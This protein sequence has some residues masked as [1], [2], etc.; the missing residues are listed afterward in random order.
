[1]R[2]FLDVVKEAGDLHA[3]GHLDRASILYENL[4]GAQPDDPIVLYLLGTLFSQQNRF[5][6]AITLLRA[7]TKTGGDE[8]P[9][10]WHNL[11]TAYRNEG[12]TEDA[13]EAYQKAL[14][15]E[16]D[17]ADTLAMMSGSY[18]NTGEPEKALDYADQSLAI[19]DSPQARNH[20]ALANLELGNWR[21]A[22]PDYEARFELDTHSVSNRPYTCPRWHGEKVKKLAIHGEQGV[23]DEIMFLSCYQ[24]ASQFAEEIVIEVEHRLRSLIEKSLEVP[25]YGSH[26]E[27]ITAHPDVDAY[28]PMGSLPGLFRN[29]DKDFPRN[30]YLKADGSKYKALLGD[31]PIVGIAWH[32]GTKGTHQQLRNAPLSLWKTLITDNPDKTFVSLQYGEDA[33]AQ[34]QELGI[35]HWQEVI[36][37]FEQQ[38][39]LIEA[40][41]LVVSVC[42][43]ATH[44]AGA[45]GAKCFCLTPD[46]AAWRYGLEG[47]VLWYGEHLEL[48]RQEGK[49]WEHVFETVGKRLKNADY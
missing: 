47:P 38:A 4:L 31:D 41:D 37:N 8:L 39:D 42:Q 21:E 24:D 36:D 9:E 16:S 34:A 29:D 27:L 26:Q 3:Q 15:L 48:I 35:I 14:A 6:S 2:E 23:G 10:V 43:T 46:H 20:R 49:G 44:I 45:I 28:I 19:E 1:M 40:C 25:C 7:A 18:I 22:W 13:R 11:G 17:R 12:H 5:G 33:A 32:G 30:R